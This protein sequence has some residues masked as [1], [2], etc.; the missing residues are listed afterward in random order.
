[1]KIVHQGDK[2][3]V[4]SKKALTDGIWFDNIYTNNSWVFSQAPPILN[5]I[6]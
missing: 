1:M 4:V 2:L 3:Y 5:F 6:Y